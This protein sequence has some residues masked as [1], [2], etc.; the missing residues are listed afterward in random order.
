LI[1]RWKSGPSTPQPFLLSH[2]Y[3]MYYQDCPLPHSRGPGRWVPPV[4]LQKLASPKAQRPGGEIGRR[5]GL[6]I[7]RTGRPACCFARSLSSS[8]GCV[9]FAGARNAFR[10]FGIR[11]SVPSPQFS[12]TRSARSTQAWQY[13][14]WLF[15]LTTTVRWRRD[16]F[17]VGQPS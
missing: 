16:P 11:H 10:D 8:F 6:K 5:N 7:G 12:G 14:Q 15:Q 13:S 2:L 3:Y 9:S 17:F 4:H 1:H